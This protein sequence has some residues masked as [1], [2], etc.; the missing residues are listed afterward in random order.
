MPYVAV[1]ECSACGGVTHHNLGAGMPLIAPC[2]S[3]GGRR[4]IARFF[5]DRRRAEREVSVDRRRSWLD[6][7]E[8]VS[9]TSSGA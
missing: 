5:S 3:C 7:G 6:L 1:M 9:S 4:H 8:A 2:P